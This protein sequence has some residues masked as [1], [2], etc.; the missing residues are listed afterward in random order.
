MAETHASTG[1]GFAVRSYGSIAALWVRASLAYPTSFVLMS[2]GGFLITGLDFV[3]LWLMF[4]HIDT[5]GGFTLMEIALLYG[6]SGVGLRTAD[7]L[8]GS[9]E[10]IGLYVRTGLRHYKKTGP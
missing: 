3:A 5:L 6:A 9:V 4:S 2:V 7:L 1:W 10:R 8:I